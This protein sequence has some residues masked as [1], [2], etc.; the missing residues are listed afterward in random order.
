[1]RTLTSFDGRRRT[2]AQLGVYI[3]GAEAR[4]VAALHAMGRAEAANDPEL[5]A[6]LDALRAEAATSAASMRDQYHALHAA[7]DAEAAA[8]EGAWPIH[9]G[10]CGELCGESEVKGSTGMCPD[11]LERC[12]PNEE[13]IG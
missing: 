6:L 13:G 11:C 9:C 7:D 4:E 5:V 2:R 8:Q 1:M 3:A 12:Y 10:W